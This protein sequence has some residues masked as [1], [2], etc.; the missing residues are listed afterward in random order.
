[1]R[2]SLEFALE[3]EGFTVLS[4]EDLTPALASPHVAD[5][6]CIVIDEEALLNDAFAMAAVRQF[7]KPVLLLIDRSQTVPEVLGIRVLRKPVFG[8]ALIRAIKLAG[9][10][11][12]AG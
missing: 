12:S 5:G 9:E 8:N 10:P 1:L 3:V 2:R 11:G 7:K 4:F 6:T